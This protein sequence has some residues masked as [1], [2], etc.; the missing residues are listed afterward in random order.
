MLKN[1]VEYFGSL[2]LVLCVL[3][4]IP[5][6]VSMLRFFLSPHIL[7]NLTTDANYFYI[8]SHDLPVLEAIMGACPH[9][10]WFWLAKI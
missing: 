9:A 2:W 5:E 1:P 6:A 10:K 8:M 4:H 7:T 3:H